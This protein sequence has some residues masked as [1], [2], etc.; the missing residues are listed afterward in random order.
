MSKHE[1]I[2]VQVQSY[3]LYVCVFCTASQPAGIN[4]SHEIEIQ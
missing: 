3:G 4:V 2:P 1:N